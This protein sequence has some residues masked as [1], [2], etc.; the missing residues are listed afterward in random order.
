MPPTFATGSQRQAAMH[1]PSRV[2]TMRGSR[3]AN[4]PPTVMTAIGGRQMYL[5]LNGAGQSLLGWA[6]LVLYVV[7]FAWIALAFIL[8]VCLLTACLIAF[9]VE[10]RI[11]LRAIHVRKEILD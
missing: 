4:T 2:R 3:L 10:V 9:M 11:S 8:S 7:L 6:V 5:V 1:D